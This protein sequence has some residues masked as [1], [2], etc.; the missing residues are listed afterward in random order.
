MNLTSIMPIA[1]AVVLVGVLWLARSTSQSRMSDDADNPNER[2]NPANWIGPIYNNPKD[3]NL[4]VPKR[5]GMGTTVNFAHPMGKLILIVPLVLALLLLLRP[6][7]Y[8]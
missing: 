3:P 4:F 2:D 5:L 6:L 1:I 8:H 7:L